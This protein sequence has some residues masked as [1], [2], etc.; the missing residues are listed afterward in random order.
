MRTK[1]VFSTLIN[2]AREGR[3]YSIDLKGHNLK[4]GDKVYVKNGKNMSSDLFYLKDDLKDYGI[5]NFKETDLWGL[6][7]PSLYYQFAH[8][9]PTRKD[10]HKYA[11]KPIPYEEM[12]M[13]D[14]VYGKTRHEMKAVLEGA[15]LLLSCGGILQWQDDKHWFWQCPDCKD[16]VV[17]KS[18]VYNPFKKEEE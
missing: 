1:T 16:L 2:Q 9:K 8:S 14:L 3:P 4:I 6:V 7:I 11:F 10:R 12:N 17:L 5:E 13:L 15:I 18:W